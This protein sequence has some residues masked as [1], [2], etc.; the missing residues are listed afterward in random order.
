M[1]KLSIITVNLN[2]KEGLQKTL[3]SVFSQTFADYEYIIIDGGS[4]DGSKELIEKHKNKFVYW[5]SEKDKGI[6][7]AMNKGIMQAKGDL[8]IFLNSGD[9][10]ISA[11]LFDYALDK[12]DTNKADLFFCG[13]IWDDP[14]LR[15]FEYAHKKNICYVEDLRS[16]NF[17]HPGTFYKRILFDKIGLFNENYKILGDYDWNCRALIKFKIPFQ[18][19][20]IITAYFIADGIST[21]ASFR[22]LRRIEEKQ[23][24]ETYF[25]N[26]TSKSLERIK[27]PFFNKM[28]KNKFQ[29]KLNR[30]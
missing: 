5:V 13:F 17:P 1:P 19:L 20:N 21:K 11:N 29:E 3:E 4:T 18:Y 26:K 10:Y 15:V 24:K 9:Y 6:Y 23:I 30:V 12:F 2:N 25:S 28:L 7:N 8:V 16:S 14:V 27:L 22:D